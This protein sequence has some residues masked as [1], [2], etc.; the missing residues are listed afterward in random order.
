MLARAFSASILGLEAYSIEIEVDIAS[1]LPA[2]VVVGLPDA[3]VKESKDRIKSAIKNSSF[4]YSTR[5]ITVNLAPAD[6][7]KE[8]PSFD[9]PISLGLLAATGQLTSESLKDYIILGE[10]AL[11]GR[12]RPIKGALPIALSLRRGS[13]KKL[14]IPEENIAEAAV[15]EDV[16]V[17][18]VGT[19]QEAVSFINGQSQLAPHK[20]NLDD[21]L[22]GLSD[23][24][25]DFSDV[26]GQFSV[27]RALEIAA[28]GAHNVLM[29]GPPGAGKTMLARRVPTI[30]PDMSLEEALEITRIHSVVGLLPPAQALVTTRPFRSPHHTSSDIALVGG[31]VVPKPG[32]V[33]LAHNGVLFLDELPEFGREA[34]EVLRQPLEDGSVTV[35]RLA[36]TLTFPSRFLLICAMNPCPCGYF[37]A[38][39]KECHCTPYQIQRY[40]SRISGPLLD[41]I[42]IH[43]EVPALEYKELTE[44]REGEPSEDIRRRVNGARD[45]QRERLRG[46]RIHCNASMNQK[47]IKKY[48]RL[49][50]D[51]KELLKMAINELGIS[52]RAYDRILKVARTIAD[53]AASEEILPDHI[54]EAIQYR[55]LDR[56]LWA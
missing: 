44:E 32:E 46:E 53:L 42:D 1:G 18:G 34:L 37:S 26:K 25:V 30:I 47:Q 2:V 16:Q 43:I 23:Y 10:L 11:D 28:A 22:K 52:A 35:S 55:S 29:I 41:R 9:L 21:I 5:R 12:V 38:P 15:V 3:A 48:C 13:R 4:D 17:Y 27:K 14:I 51:G 24:E 45:I 7:K 54:S 36:N 33:S 8:G 20:V 56:N 39:R 40:L 50:E 6:I 31:G 19:L 49:D